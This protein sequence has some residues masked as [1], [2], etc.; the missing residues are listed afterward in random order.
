MAFIAWE[1]IHFVTCWSTE[2]RFNLCGIF[3]ELLDEGFG[4]MCAALA[5]GSAKELPLE[6]P[7]RITLLLFRRVSPSSPGWTRPVGGIC[8]CQQ[9]EKQESM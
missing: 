8:G 3:L 4:V 6:T 1:L 2:E 5:L 9:E 7:A